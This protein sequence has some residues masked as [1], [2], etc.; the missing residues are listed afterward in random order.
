MEKQTARK[1]AET[2][3]VNPLK[4]EKIFVRFVPQKTGAPLDP[5]HPCSGGLADG[6]TVRLC[7]PILRSTGVYKNILTDAEKSYL[8]KELGM[9]YNALSV[10]K[11]EN[12]YW[13]NY[14][15]TLDK[16]GLHLDLSNPEDFIKYK[17]I[18]A[19]SDIVAP[20]I[21]ERMDRYKQTYRFEIV[22]DD[23]ETALENASMDAT[24]ESYKQYGKIEDDYDTVRTLVQ[25]LDGRP[26][27]ANSKMSFFRARVKKLVEAN[28]KEFLR[29]ITDPMLHTKMLILRGT[30]LGQ[31]SKR[32][33]YYYLK[34]D[35]SP[36]CDNGEDPTLSIAAR[37]LNQPTHQ[38]VKFLL[39]SAVDD[40]RIR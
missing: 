40:N 26:Y 21:K 30:E 37:Y 14:Y 9:D 29:Q 12:N 36:L 6:S 27:D 7:V 22:R 5:H 33:D 1:P 18:S 35:G 24:L 2:V 4:N 15:V 3:A 31:L 10:Y 19:N 13:D 34:S 8:E 11:K 25:L 17:V 23:E 38:D 16:E 28:P 39:E 20:S 32:G